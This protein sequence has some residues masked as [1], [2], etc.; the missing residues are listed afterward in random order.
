MSGGG[1]FAAS[2]VFNLG[3]SFLRQSEQSAREQLARANAELKIAQ[4]LL[5]ENSRVGERLRI[6]RDLHD[7]LGHHLTALSLQL[8]VASRRVNGRAA[9]HVREAHAIA[10]LLLSDIRD[11]VGELRQTGRIDLSAV[12]LP[13]AATSEVPRVH[14]E[15]PEPFYLDDPAHANAW[16]RCVQEIL[17]NAT[18]HAGA[19]HLWIEFEQDGDGITLH[20]RDDGIGSADLKPGYGLTGMRE[21]IEERG[22]RVEF[23]PVP[24]RGFEVL[25]HMP[26]QGGSS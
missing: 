13:L 22:G 9:D 23:N 3:Q 24:G 7:S 15:M 26:A 18:R 2:H 5:A 14:L 8:D 1:A 16:L 11:V 25:A 12:L 4:E 19:R 17:T 20:A 10:K 6:S 21:R